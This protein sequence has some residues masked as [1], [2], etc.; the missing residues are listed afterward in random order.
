MADLFCPV[1]SY[2]PIEQ[3]CSDP[4]RHTCAEE[5]FVFD[6]ATTMERVPCMGSDCEWWCSTSQACSVKSLCA[7][8]GSDSGSGE[9]SVNMGDILNKL[10]DIFDKLDFGL[11]DITL[12]DI[13]ALLKA[14]RDKLGLLVPDC[15]ETSGSGSGLNCPNVSLDGLY[16]LLKA[17]FLQVKAMF[18]LPECSESGSV[19]VSGSVSCPRFCFPNME[20]LLKDI[21]EGI[22]NIDIGD[23]DIGDINIPDISIPEMA[24]LLENFKNLAEKFGGFEKLMP[25]IEKMQQFSQH[26][27]DAHA[28][29]VK[30]LSDELSLT[31][32]ASQVVTTPAGNIFISEYAFKQDLDGNN[33][34]YGCDFKFGDSAPSTFQNIEQMLPD[35][36][37]VVNYAYMVEKTCAEGLR[38]DPCPPTIKEACGEKTCEDGYE[39]G[40]ALAGDC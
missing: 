27:H 10:D 32:C 3:I 23:I 40:K 7:S 37:P 30:H 31:G 20:L 15:K 14:M 18:G 33:E 13:H 16:D 8:S 39:E 5:G 21:A 1:L 17:L 22:N 25:A 29:P 9:V 12:D 2:F 28:H 4:T 24:E 38:E 35:T 11:N 34:I 36:I 26:M 6:Y 19:S